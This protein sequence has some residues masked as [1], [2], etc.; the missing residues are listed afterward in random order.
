MVGDSSTVNNTP[1]FFSCE[2]VKAPR[3]IR[4]KSKRESGL[5]ALLCEDYCIDL[6]DSLFCIRIKTEKKR[7]DVLYFWLHRL[8]FKLVFFPSFSFIL[9]K[10]ILPVLSFMNMYVQKVQKPCLILIPHGDKCLSNQSEVT[11]QLCNIQMWSVSGS[12]PVW[13][14]RTLQTLGCLLE[15]RRDAGAVRSLLYPARAQQHFVDIL[16]DLL[17]EGG[18]ERCL[19]TLQHALPQGHVATSKVEYEYA[20]F[21]SSE[22][23]GGKKQKLSPKMFSNKNIISIKKKKG[24]GTTLSTWL[25]LWAWE[26]CRPSAGMS[27]LQM[28]LG[29]RSFQPCYLYCQHQKW[30][31]RRTDFL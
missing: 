11:Q 18:G 13:A 19:H 6:H 21:N 30:W 29:G 14:Q 2:G 16:F 4:N 8:F 17:G 24:T 26:G 9:H 5:N 3:Q 23:G 12:S 27:F 22:I 1:E 31:R 25:Y 7:L 20:W 28:Q 10:W 15:R